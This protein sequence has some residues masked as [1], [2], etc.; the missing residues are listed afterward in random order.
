MKRILLI[1]LLSF[2][3]LKADITEYFPKQDANVIDQENLLSQNVKNDVNNILQDH[4]KRKSN[5][6]IVVI[7]KSLNDYKI[8]D[9]ANQLK[10]YWKVEDKN[11]LVL[12]S[13]QEKQIEI[14]VSNELKNRVNNE[15]LNEIIEYTIKPNFKAKQYELGTL[16][17]INEI[18]LALQYEYIPK[19]NKANFSTNSNYVLFLTF[20]FFVVLFLFMFIN[21]IS[22]KRKNIFIYRISKSFMYS[23]FFAFVALFISKIYTLHYLI[24]FGVV[25]IL[26]FLVCYFFI[27]EYSDFSLNEN[28]KYSLNSKNFETILNELN[29]I[30]KDTTLNKKEF[31]KQQQ[32][33]ANANW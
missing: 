9:Y 24:I 29:T 16:K 14:N 12:I 19:T 23:S 7:L 20:L 28:S 8:E 30:S 33:N 25:F 22:K 21:S 27:K 18:I 10:R 15:I 3:F 1:L 4:Q 5:Q 31:L 17:A 26:V 2:S 32:G 13:M 11:V 6:I